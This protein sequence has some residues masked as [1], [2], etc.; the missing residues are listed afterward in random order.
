MTTLCHQFQLGLLTLSP[1]RRSSL[2]SGPLL[3]PRC[4]LRKRLVS[5]WNS[6]EFVSLPAGTSALLYVH[7]RLIRVY[8]LFS[9]L[10]LRGDGGDGA[11]P[12]RVLFGSSTSCVGLPLFALFVS[13]LVPVVPTD[14]TMGMFFLEKKKTERRYTLKKNGHRTTTTNATIAT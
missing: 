12:F 9:S 2:E 8:P 5:S 13:R 11:R 14:T 4:T 6:D 7:S 3:Y 1:Y 10:F